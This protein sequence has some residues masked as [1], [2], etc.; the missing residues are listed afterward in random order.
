MKRSAALFSI[1]FILIPAQIALA[2]DEDAPSLKT[3]I[4]R[5]RILIGDRI[6]YKAQIYSKLDLE[7][8]F[9]KF[10]D[11]KIEECEIK[12]SGREVIKSLFGGRADYIYWLDITSYY[13]G[14]RKIPPIEIRYREKG[15]GN[16]KSI[17]TEELYFTV[18]SVL[19]RNV[20]LYDVKDI[21]GLIYPFNFFKLFLWIIFAFFIAW[22]LIIIFKKLRKKAA[23]KLAHEVAIEALRVAQAEYSKTGDVKDYYFK[24]SDVVRRYIEIVF[25]LRAP[26]MTT[27]EFLASLGTSWKMSGAY[28]ELLKT[29]MLACDLVKFAKH[30]PKKDEIDHVFTTAKKFIEETQKENVSV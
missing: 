10:K 5:K 19:P 1:F 12:D 16:W 22:V 26:E 11:N 6:R 13:T 28:K 4:N 15:E 29:F 21:K 3:S 25:K 14:K 7:T 8:E 30:A 18:E 24:I 2:I 23:P 9:A 20:K 17:K 27:E